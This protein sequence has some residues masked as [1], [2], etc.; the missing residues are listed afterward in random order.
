MAKNLTST[1]HHLTG[2]RFMGETPE[3]QR[4][5]IDNSKTARTGPSPMQLVLHALAAC[6]AMDVVT[7]LG[8][9]RLEIREYRIEMLGERPDA[10][11]SP[12]E[13]ITARH[14]FDVPGLDEATAQRFVQL[15]GEKYCSVGAT[16]NTEIVNEVELLHETLTTDEMA[17]QAAREVE[18]TDSAD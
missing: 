18:E 10:V 14:V 13:R 17:E 6:T 5:M 9:R 8:K 2:L 3:G 11:P 16:L 4:T 7:M 15:A 12:F 1:L